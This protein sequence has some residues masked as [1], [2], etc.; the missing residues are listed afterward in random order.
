MDVDSVGARQL[1]RLVSGAPFFLVLVVGMVLAII[2]RRRYP[3]PCLL[4]LLG[5]TLL[6]LLSLAQTFLASYLFALL[7][8]NSWSSTR[9]FW[10]FAI[11]W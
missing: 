7:Y 2:H 3:R 1:I 9:E 5:C 6:L 10:T 11:V 4:A 8:D